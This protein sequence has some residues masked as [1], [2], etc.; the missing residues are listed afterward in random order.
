MDIALL[1]RPTVSSDRSGLRPPVSHLSISLVDV[2][3]YAFRSEVSIRELSAHYVLHAK[4]LV[5]YYFNKLIRYKCTYLLS[6]KVKKTTT[7]IIGLRHEFVY[8]FSSLAIF[9]RTLKSYFSSSTTQSNPRVGIITQ[10][11]VLVTIFTLR[12]TRLY[13]TC[14]IY[15]SVFALEKSLLMAQRGSFMCVHLYT[16]LNSLYLVTYPL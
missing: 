2:L 16:L 5:Q 13:T 1:H 14:Q 4:W 12:N 7:V 10:I 6:P 11:T 15:K 9:K 3:R 8:Y